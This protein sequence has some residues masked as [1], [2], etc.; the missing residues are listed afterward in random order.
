LDDICNDYQNQICRYQKT[1]AN[2][3]N[4]TDELIITAEGIEM[5]LGKRGEHILLHY[6]KRSNV[7]RFRW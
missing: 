2:N 3:Q 6:E 1:E 4:E 5:Q 7:A